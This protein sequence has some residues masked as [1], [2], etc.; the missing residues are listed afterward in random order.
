MTL[1]KRA[2]TSSHSYPCFSCLKIAG[3]EFSDKNNFRC[4]F[5]PGS[6]GGSD[7]PS[8][9]GLRPTHTHVRVPCVRKPRKTDFQAKLG[10]DVSLTPEV[11]TSHMTP[12]DTVPD[13][14]SL[15]FVIPMLKNLA[16]N[17]FEKNYF[18]MFL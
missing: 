17:S 10:F 15:K 4:F 3:N 13:R 18:L 8:G 6:E 11:E 1:W 5:D 16:K 12:S 7:N 2:G 14:I 9:S